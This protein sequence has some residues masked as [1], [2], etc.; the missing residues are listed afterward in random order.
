MSQRDETTEKLSQLKEQLGTDD[1]GVAGLLDRGDDT[2]GSDSADTAD[3]DTD[4][5]DAIGSGTADL[6]EIG[7]SLGRALGGLVGR[8]LGKAL[9]RNVDL[10]ERMVSLL[11]SYLETTDFEGAAESLVGATTDDGDASD[12]ASED[13]D[14]GSSEPPDDFDEMSTDELQS[15]AD[16]LMGELEERSED[17]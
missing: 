11:V 17:G 8:R 2:D 5:S 4:A 16:Q 1:G 15:M 7:E 14:N 9:G 6:P 12:T 13:D 3:G 10:D